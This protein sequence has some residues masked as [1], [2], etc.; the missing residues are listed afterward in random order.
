MKK[1]FKI[2]LLSFFLLA[3]MPVFAGTLS[4]RISVSC[5]SSEIKILEMQNSS[6]AHAGLPG[7]G[8]LYSICCS[9]VF[10]LG[11][12][13]SGNSEVVAKLSSVNG[14]LNAHVR[15][16]DQSN[17]TN[18]LSSNNIC[19]SVPINGTVSIAYQANDCSGFDT[20]LFSMNKTPSNSHIG[21]STVYLNKV[22]ATASVP[23]GLFVTS[24]SLSL[25]SVVTT[26]STP[27]SEASPDPTLENTNNLEGNDATEDRNIFQ[28][29]LGLVTGPEDN[30]QP[31]DVTPNGGIAI[32]Q[33]D[34]P[35]A[36]VNPEIVQ[37]STNPIVQN[38]A[39]V[40]AAT[41]PL[42][43]K[44]NLFS[45]ASLFGANGFFPET[46]LG[47]IIIAILIASILLLV[48]KILVKRGQALKVK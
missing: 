39:N 29:I 46:F 9:G 20:T 15:Q 24:P 37:D 31:A 22:C 12:S 13:C 44:F 40:V 48:R 36:T 33:N 42:P 18:Y 41:L 6:N 21:D 16:G 14:S 30:N 38:E 2:L 19:L 7:S 11:N 26:N 43:K 23:D 5:T 28:R 3:A 32:A 35:F 10:G 27:S 45:A 34:G 25:S 17:D 47:W 1:V 4:C 8:Y